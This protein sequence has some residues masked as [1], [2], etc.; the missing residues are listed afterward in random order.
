VICWGWN[1]NAQ[2]GRG[3]I[4]APVPP[5]HQLARIPNLTG[6]VGINLGLRHSCAQLASGVLRCWGANASGQLG[7][8]TTTQRSTPWANGFFAGLRTDVAGGYKHTCGLRFDGRV[9]CWGGNTVGELGDG[10]TIDHAF[11]G[12]VGGLDRVE[13]I[14]ALY[15]HT[16]A[17]RAEGTVWCWGWNNAGQLGD[18]TTTDRSLPV[19][20]AEVSSTVDVAA[21]RW[22]S[23]ALLADGTVRCWGDNTYGQLGDGTYT[24]SPKAVTVSGLADAV[25]IDAGSAHT[26]ALRQTGEVS[27]WG[28]NL[29]AQL[30][31]GN[32]VWSPVPVR[33]QLPTAAIEIGAGNNHTC[34]VLVNNSVYCWGAND[35][36]Q[37][38]PGSAALL[39]P[40]PTQI[41]GF[42]GAEEVAA[43]SGHS[44]AQLANGLVWCWGD[45]R[46]GQIGD[47]GPLN[48]PAFLL[49]TKVT[50]LDY[51]NHL[52]LGMN[53]SF[54]VAGDGTLRGWG[55]NFFGQ[56]GNG[57]TTSSSTPLVIAF[58]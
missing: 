28:E 30:G 1:G 33:A 26:C 39:E 13:A 3:G 10:T 53:H 15:E 22:H 5:D 48:L 9:K 6:V 23:C 8:N 11:P 58:P 14:D 38:H 34:A 17:V 25:A 20:V 55:D 37:S 18:L 24:S 52:E 21:G 45:N 19:Q 32:F 43:G 57:T 54:A 12:F 46:F 2:L 31:T 27:C 16:C 35:F 36:G 51:S 41:A 56:L 40:T 42:E 47:G 7:D 44:C 29:L 49:P 50:S 4:A